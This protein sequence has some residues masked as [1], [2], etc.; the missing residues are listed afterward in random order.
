MCD[1]GQDGEGGGEGG[2]VLPDESSERLLLG[3][4]RATEAG[5][6]ASAGM[7]RAGTRSPVSVLFYG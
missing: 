4:G 7:E 1:A 5:F 6:T 2:G 3:P